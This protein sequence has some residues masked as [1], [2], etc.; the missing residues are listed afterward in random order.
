MPCRH[1]LESR[2]FDTGGVYCDGMELQCLRVYRYCNCIAQQ[3]LRGPVFG[4]GG[5]KQYDMALE[6]LRSRSFV[7]GGYTAMHGTI[8]S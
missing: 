7:A 6:G 2:S 4:T 8:T 5:V 3:G 1:V